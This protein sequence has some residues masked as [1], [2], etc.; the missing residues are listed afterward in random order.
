MQESRIQRWF[1]F[2]AVL[3]V[4]AAAVFIMIRPAS[5]KPT[6]GENIVETPKL[7]QFVNAK[8]GIEFSYPEGYVLTEHDVGNTAERDHHAIV[9]MRAEDATNLPEAGEGP[10]SIT[11]DIYGNNI[12]KQT[13]ER[14]IHNTSASNFKL[15]IDEKIATTTVAG[16]QALSYTWDGLYRGDSTVLAHKDNIF[17]FSVTYMD[18][19]AIIRD[20]FAYMLSTVRFQ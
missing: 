14:F 15:S 7:N 20:D 16:E 3:F 6:I 19:A 8:Y 2:I 4:I 18:T 11:I 5:E 13:V 10:T 17:M 9:I 1:A 12:D